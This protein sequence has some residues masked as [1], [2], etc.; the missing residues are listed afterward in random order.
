MIGPTL[1]SVVIIGIPLRG[2]VLVTV[3]ASWSIIRTF[4]QWILGVAIVVITIVALLTVGIT[5]PS[6]SGVA[7]ALAGAPTAIPGIA[8]LP[9]RTHAAR[10]AT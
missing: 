7:P 2:I 1:R 9:P 3:V 8:S 4:S 5:L 10:C 6:P